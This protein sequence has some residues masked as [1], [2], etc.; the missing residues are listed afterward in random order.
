MKSLNKLHRLAD[1]W[2]ALTGK[3]VV[4]MNVGGPQS[5]YQFTDA[6]APNFYP[7]FYSSM[8]SFFGVENNNEIIK[9]I[10]ECPQV[11]SILANKCSAHTNGKLQALNIRNDNPLKGQKSLQW[12]GLIDRP[13]FMQN[14]EAF[15]AQRKFYVMAYGYAPELRIMPAGYE[16]GT[17]ITARW[18][19]DPAR[20]EIKWKQN[21]LPYFES[22][23]YDLIEWIKV[24]QI[25]GRILEIKN[26][27]DVYFHTDTTPF[28][29]KSYLPQSRISALKYPINNIVKGYKTE[30]RVISKPL[31]FLSNQAKD[32]I[33]TLP[34]D[35]L[36]KQE[37]QKAFKEYGTE[38]EDQND[39]II[40]NATM[41]WQHMMYP[42]AQLQMIELRS[43]NTAIICDGL[44]YPFDLMGKDKGS[45]F[46]NGDSADKRL[47]Q[48]FIIPEACNLD[49]QT[50]E[51]LFGELNKVNYVTTFDHVPVL[52]ENQKEKADVRQ[53]NVNA[54]KIEFDANM[55]TYNQV[56]VSNGRDETTEPWGELYAFQIRVQYPDFYKSITDNQATNETTT[57]TNTSGN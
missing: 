11:A 22:D 28:R 6:T 52:Q 15:E 49:R 18:L 44:G 30:A 36:E 25:D 21:V 9:A 27:R 56:L 19:L 8:V 24:T 17:V 39:V 14:G 34:I 37:L 5:G 20:T 10:K 41:Q 47:Y 1:A 51:C 31:G 42:I 50:S 32:N 26:P 48:N 53:T 3:S 43:A 29:Y 40:S 45:T 46:N 7:E 23:I 2:D 12:Q 35:K 16:R 55:A 4:S 54:S 33:S 13:N 38:Y 57:Q